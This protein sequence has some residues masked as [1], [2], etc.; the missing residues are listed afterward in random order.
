MPLAMGELF[1]NP[2]EYKRLIEKRYIDYIRCHISM[3]G[4]LTP[5]IKLAHFADVY[6]VRTAWHGPF[7]LSAIGAAA[8]IHLDLVSPNFG[9]QEFSGFTP[10]E[11]E[12]FPGAPEARNG[13]IYLN[14]KP[15]LGVDI[16]EEA[17]KKYPPTF[18]DNFW[19]K[20]RLPDGTCVRA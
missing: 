12:V 18:R 4:G 17:A 1:V 13:Y 11:R 7:D 15:G 10:E 8:Q 5:A 3:I 9:V 6:G 2:M 20:C 16:D 19:L 14:D